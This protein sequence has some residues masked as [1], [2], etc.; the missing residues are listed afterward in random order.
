MKKAKVVFQKCIQDSQE[1]GSN[2]ESMVSRVFFDLEIDGQKYPDLYVDIKQT[3]GGSFETTPIEVGSPQGY[4]GPFNYVAFR[5]AVERY[6]RSLVGAQGSAIH[7]EDA[8]N[9]RMYNNLLVKV[10]SV[11][12]EVHGGADIGW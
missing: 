2:D 1:Y 9:I 11:E 4:R 8:R 3:V 12:F 6:Y 10:Q 7:I 5:N